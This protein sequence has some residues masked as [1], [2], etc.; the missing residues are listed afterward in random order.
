MKE[1]IFQREYYRGCGE[2]VT[3]TFFRENGQLY[4]ETYISG[5]WS[6]E[7][8]IEVVAIDEVEKAIRIEQD[9]Q[10]DELTKHIDELKKL[11]KKLKKLLTN[12]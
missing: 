7:S 6:A 1:I 2:N 4:R 11:Q 3:E 9:R 10:I 5:Y 12:K 8:K